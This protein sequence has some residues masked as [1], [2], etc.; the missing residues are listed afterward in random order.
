MPVGLESFKGSCSNLSLS[1]N[2]I[3]KDGSVLLFAA[4]G[5]LVPGY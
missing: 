5:G 1:P 4:R 2:G 3:A